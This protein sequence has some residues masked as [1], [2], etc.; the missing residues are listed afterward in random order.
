MCVFARMHH[1]G[2]TLLSCIG[3]GEALKYESSTLVELNLSHNYLEDAGLILLSEGMY[4][5]CSLEKL[6]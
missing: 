4:A 1:C 3:I 6:K 2:L 5:W